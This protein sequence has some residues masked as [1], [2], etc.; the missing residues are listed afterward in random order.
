MPRR[1]LALLL[2]VGL[3]GACAAQEAYN[4]L[5]DEDDD[6]DIEDDDY[7]KSHWQKTPGGKSDKLMTYGEALKKASSG[8]AD[9]VSMMLTIMINLPVIVIFAHLILSIVIATY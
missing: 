2:A 5:E 1:W 3:V 6:S 7:G 9:T 4:G 8:Q